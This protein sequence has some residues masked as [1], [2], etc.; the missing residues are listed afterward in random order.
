MTGAFMM[1]HAMAQEAC[2]SVWVAGQAANRQGVVMPC[3][4]W[5]RDNSPFTLAHLLLAT[6]PRADKMMTWVRTPAPQL[7][8]RQRSTLSAIWPIEIS[9]AMMHGTRATGDERNVPSLPVSRPASPVVHTTSST[10]PPKVKPPP[11]AVRP[12][13]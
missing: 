6:R 10:A 7:M 9:T 11:K 4:G 13:F 5:P 1:A 3:A 8:P 2:S 12:H